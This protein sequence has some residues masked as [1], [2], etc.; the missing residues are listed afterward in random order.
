[1]NS[2][3]DITDPWKEVTEKPSNENV[4][5]KVVKTVGDVGESLQFKPAKQMIKRRI[6]IEKIMEQLKDRK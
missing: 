6:G 1:M 3:Y 4:V 2:D 5:D